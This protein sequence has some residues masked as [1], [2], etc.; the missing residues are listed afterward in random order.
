VKDFGN[1][2]V[3]FSMS[4]SQFIAVNSILFVNQYRSSTLFHLTVPW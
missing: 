1:S 4:I 2:D 3:E